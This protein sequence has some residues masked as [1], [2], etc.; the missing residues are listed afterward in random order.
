MYQLIYLALSLIG[1]GITIAQHGTPK[2]ENH[3][4]WVSLIAF[5]VSIFLLIKGGFFDNLINI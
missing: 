5:L 3:N 1:L 4:A 2:K